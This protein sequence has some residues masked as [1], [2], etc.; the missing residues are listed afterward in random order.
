MGMTQ[1][2]MSIGICA[3]E[4]YCRLERGKRMPHPKEREA[5]LERL[6]VGWGYF[7]GD[8]ETTDYMAFEYLHQFKDASRR[9]EWKKAEELMGE[10]RKRLDMESVNNR[11]YVG[12]MEN[13][14]A[15]VTGRIGAEE[16]YRRDKELLELSVKRKDLEKTELYYFSYIEILLHTHLA[17]VLA[18]LGKD[19]EGIRLLKR[20][21][22]KMEKSEVGFEYW[23]ESI[24]L[25]IFNLA[26][27]LSDVGEYGESLKYMGDFID[28][29]F[30]LSDG[31]FLGIG[32]GERVLDLDKL[33]GTDKATCDRLLI[34]VFYLTDFYDQEEDHKL[35]QEYYET[36]YDANRKWY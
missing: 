21:L 3:A 24:K 29:C 31:K 1:L 12:M 33:G 34:Q 6:K 20:M 32:I 28:L 16:F 2:R 5:I 9:C 4:T 36:H 25:S 26:N 18:I 22:E 10:I 14:I 13:W 30:K 15:Y 23:W 17:N 7:R 35:V 8:L 19:R 27:M 11:Q